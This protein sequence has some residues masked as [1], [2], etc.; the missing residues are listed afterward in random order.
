[1]NPSKMA[2]SKSS[3]EMQRQDFVAILNAAEAEGAANGFFTVDE[4][5]TSLDAII[6]EARRYNTNRPKHRPTGRSYSRGEQ[7]PRSH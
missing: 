3:N 5:A 6:A 4:V 1:M 2:C 7:E